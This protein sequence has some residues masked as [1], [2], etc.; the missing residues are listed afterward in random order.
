MQNDHI[1]LLL[2]K[3]LSE[4]IKNSGPLPFEEFMRLALYH[5]TLGY[6]C[7]DKTKLGAQ[8]DFVTAPLISSLF[9]KALAQQIIEI[10]K[11]CQ[12]KS[13]ILELGA[14]NGKMAGDILNALNE[15][16]A[17]PEKY[18]IL[19]ISPSLIEQ[20]KTYLQEKL[21]DLFDRFVWIEDLN[22]LPQPFVGTIVANEFL[23]A[24]PVHLFQIDIQHQPLMGK[25]DLTAEDHFTLLFEKTSDPLFYQTLDNELAALQTPLPPGYL[26]EINLNLIAWVQDLSRLLTQGV[27][28][29]I[30][31]GFTREEYFHPQRNQGTLMCHT[32]HKTH[33]D[34]FHEIGLQDITAHVNFSHLRDT[35]ESSGLQTLGF[36]NQAA[37]LL[38]L[39]ILD[40]PSNLSGKELILR[41]QA[42]QVLLQPHEMG[43]LFKVLALGKG[44]SDPLQG[45]TVKDYQYKL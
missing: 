26:S 28:L 30:D 44:F 19:E 18:F 13:F 27:I 41:S 39:H 23:D 35:A 7:H 9:S 10:Q 34:Y 37:F 4:K 40:D 36:T 16:N 24:L 22:A 14:G 3:I 31:Y 2:T 6:Y 32:G 29:L 20:Q 5:P 42:L 33:P 17:L 21:P 45:F 8:G 11:L 38:G 25:V 43:E 15:Q 12:E 1:P